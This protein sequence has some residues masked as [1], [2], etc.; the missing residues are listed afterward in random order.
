MVSDKIGTDDW[1]GDVRDDKWPQ[2]FATQAQI[3]F[4][5]LLPDDFYRSAICS[6]QLY[7]GVSQVVRRHL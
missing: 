5:G 3:Q 6:K 1:A 4:D 2:E 7:V